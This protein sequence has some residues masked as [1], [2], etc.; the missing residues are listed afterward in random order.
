MKIDWL[1]LLISFGHYVWENKLVILAA[2]GALG[3]AA[4][5]TMPSPDRKWWSIQTIKEWLY[6]FLHQFINSKNTRLS[7]ATIPTP[8]ENKSNPPEVKP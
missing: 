8:P 3:T 4:V 7:N 2:I 6:D 1:N 5:V